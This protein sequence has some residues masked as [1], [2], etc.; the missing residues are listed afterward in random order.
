M[1]QQHTAD[2]E[3]GPARD[4]DK[5]PN[6]I[7]HG[8]PTCRPLGCYKLSLLEVMMVKHGAISRS[9]IYQMLR[10]K[11]ARVRRAAFILL[12]A[13]NPKLSRNGELFMEI[14]RFIWDANPSYNVYCEFSKRHLF[15]DG[16][17]NAAL[18]VSVRETRARAGF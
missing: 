6:T 17:N 10:S 5:T 2:R 4:G 14:V 12:E 8:A 15:H 18:P 1:P 7:I 16:R 11:D 9:H 3:L 13:S